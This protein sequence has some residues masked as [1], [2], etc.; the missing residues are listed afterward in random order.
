[1]PLGYLGNVVHAVGSLKLLNMS[2]LEPQKLA[3]VQGRRPAFLA[4]S[5]HVS[6][7]ELYSGLS[8]DTEGWHRDLGQICLLLS[9]CLETVLGT[10]SVEQ[11]STL[12]PQPHVLYQPCPWK[13]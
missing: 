9:E 10:P 3:R 1:M 7:Q 11:V 12:H 8:G 2:P 4:A 6:L 5:Q 13:R